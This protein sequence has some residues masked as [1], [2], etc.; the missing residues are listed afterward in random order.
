MPLLEQSS[1]DLPLISQYKSDPGR[2]G[3]PGLCRREF[4]CPRLGCI[5][6]TLNRSR[7][8]PLRCNN[9]SPQASSEWFPTCGNSSRCPRIRGALQDHESVGIFNFELRNLVGQEY[10]YRLVESLRCLCTTWLPEPDA[11]PLDT[12][13]LQDKTFALFC[14]EFSSWIGVVYPPFRPL[15]LC[16]YKNFTSTYLQKL[17]ILFIIYGMYVYD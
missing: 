14:P 10:I 7:S 3:N 9:Q 6:R 17:F 1:A 2:R 5:G 12:W 13:V 11:L 8:S 16:E 15:K 4:L